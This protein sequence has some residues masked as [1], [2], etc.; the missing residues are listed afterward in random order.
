M[1]DIFGKAVRTW[2]RARRR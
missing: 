2:V 1:V